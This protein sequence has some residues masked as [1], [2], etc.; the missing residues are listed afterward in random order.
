MCWLIGCA[1]RSIR[2]RSITRKPLAD[3]TR[4]PAPRRVR[5][6]ALG[7]GSPRRCEDGAV[8]RSSVDEA[9]PYRDERGLGAI[10]Y[11][12]LLE[13]GREIVPDRAV[14]EKQLTGNL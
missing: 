7:T 4:C 1:R 2:A 5:T 6:S 3:L 14:R 10:G 13:N 8:A 9:V 12:E 11:P